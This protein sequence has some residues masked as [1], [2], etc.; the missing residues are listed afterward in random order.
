[1]IT[2]QLARAVGRLHDQSIYNIFQRA[3][4][5]NR[6]MSL[7]AVYASRKASLL[8]VQSPSTIPGLSCT[9][10]GKRL[11]DAVEIGS[12]PVVETLIDHGASVDACTFE[13][14]GALHIGASL[15]RVEVAQLLL[16]RKMIV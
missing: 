8:R 11:C 12:Y 5:R 6:V 7:K 1:M 14:A 3:V 15:H 13:G 16:A 2:S 10:E 9:A 4:F